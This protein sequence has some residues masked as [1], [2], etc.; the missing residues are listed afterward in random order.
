MKTQD[1]DK[2]LSR[3]IEAYDEMRGRL[4]MDYMGKWVVFYGMELIGVHDDFQDAAEEAVSK[5][6]RG[7]YLIKQVGEPPLV[8]P[9]SVQ[10][11]P[12][13]ADS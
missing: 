8:L 13:R 2:L 11:R 6:G 10:Y 5:F 9:A 4:E 1:G 3:Q 12:I 7:P